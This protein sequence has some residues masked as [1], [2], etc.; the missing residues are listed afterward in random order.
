MSNF[1]KSLEF[2]WFL[3]ISGEFIGPIN[4][5]IIDLADYEFVQIVCFDNRNESEI[6][7]KVK[8]FKPSDPDL[9]HNQIIPLIPIINKTSDSKVPNVL[10]LAIDSTSYMNF[11]RLFKRTENLLKKNDFLELR[12]YT[13]VGM[14][15][16]PNMIPFLTGHVAKEIIT[17][18]NL[19]TI[20]FDN[21]PIIWRKYSNQ[22]F[23]TAFAEEMSVYG[24]FHYRSNGFKRKPTD[25]Q[26]RPFHMEILKSKYNK[27]CY[28]SQTETEVIFQIIFFLFV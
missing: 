22:N 5:R 21:W 28:I 9:I 11:K 20:Y 26:T 15:T 8:H 13:K 1:I 24:L 10:L 16:F 18:E 25:Y 19:D 2:I 3:W 4:E 7:E 6:Q 27:Y 17:E 12:G 14:N 23:V